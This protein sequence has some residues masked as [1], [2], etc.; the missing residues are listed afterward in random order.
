[1]INSTAACSQC[2]DST[3]ALQSLVLHEESL[4]RRANYEGG[5]SYNVSLSLD[6]NDPLTYNEICNRADSTL[7]SGIAPPT[8]RLRRRRWSATT[9]SSLSTRPTSQTASVRFAAHCKVHT[10]YKHSMRD[11]YFSYTIRILLH[12][13][14]F[15]TK[16]NA[17][18][19]LDKRKPE[20]RLCTN[21]Y[22]QRYGVDYQETF[23][24][25][26]TNHAP[27]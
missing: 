1:M 20:A 5:F 17:D 25:T 21:G 6:A 18:G 23:S 7:K 2:V 11:I 12:K 9:P 16:V 3:F 27:S 26:I 22:S 10:L 8:S 4:I 14:V 15:K 19:T 24:P 13:W